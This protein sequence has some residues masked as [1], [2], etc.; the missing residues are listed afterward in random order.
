MF[1]AFFW[2]RGW[3]LTLL[4]SLLPRAFLFLL[5]LSDLFQLL[6]SDGHTQLKFRRLEVKPSLEEDNRREAQTGPVMLQHNPPLPIVLIPPLPPSTS[7]FGALSS[8][9]QQ[10]TAATPA[11]P[12]LAAFPCSSSKRH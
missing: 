1:G 7:M 6:R 10:Q 9:P 12:G 4:T 8:T 3:G 2:E 5:L 11:R